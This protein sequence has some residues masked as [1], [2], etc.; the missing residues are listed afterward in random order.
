MTSPFVLPLYGVGFD[1]KGVP[2][3]VCPIMEGGRVDHYFERRKEQLHGQTTELDRECIGLLY[4]IARGMLYLHEVA[5]VIHTDLKP[6]NALVTRDGRGLVTDFGFPLSRPEIALSRCLVHCGTSLRSVLATFS[7][8]K[9][10]QQYLK[11][12]RCLSFCG[13]DLG[14]LVDERFAIRGAR[15]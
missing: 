8:L 10:K 14:A 15:R 1:N 5:G 13:Y 9:R 2:F 12:R 11:G 4:D 6:G 7:G 3:F